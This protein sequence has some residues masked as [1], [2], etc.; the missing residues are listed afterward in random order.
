MP[1]RR[2]A[3]NIKARGV[4]AVIAEMLGKPQRGAAHLGDDAIEL[5][6]RRQRILN[7]REV[8]IVRQ[9]AFGKKVPSLSFICQ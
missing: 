3:R 7:E 4:G 8:D 1:P 5:Y 6:R 2:M 9:H